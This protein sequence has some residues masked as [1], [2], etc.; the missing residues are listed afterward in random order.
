MITFLMNAR[1][2]EANGPFL[3]LLA[4]RNH[5]GILEEALFEVFQL[6]ALRLLD[7][8]GNLAT[9]V[10]EATD[11]DEVLC[12]AATSGHCRGTDADTTRR[13]RRDIS[14]NTIAVERDRSTLTNLLDLGTCEPMRPHIP[15]DEVIVC[16]IAGQLVAL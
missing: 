15:E 7:S 6:L 9:T 8:Q 2:T 3:D 13:Q 16:A 14:V 1:V 5:V 10:K 4:E 12:F 11:L